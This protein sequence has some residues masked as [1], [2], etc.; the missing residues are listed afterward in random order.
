MKTFITY[1]KITGDIRGS[2]SCLDCDL[3]KQVV[4]PDDA[5]METETHLNPDMWYIDLATMTLVPKK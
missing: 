1:D 4:D 3:D 2:G 5:V